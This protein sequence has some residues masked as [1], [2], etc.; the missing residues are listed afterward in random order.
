MPSEQSL[1][2]RVVADREKWQHC[3]L[4][5]GMSGTYYVHNDNLVSS[6][7]GFASLWEALDFLGRRGWQMAAIDPDVED[8]DEDRTVYW[9]KRRLVG[10]AIR[11]GHI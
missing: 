9:F 10:D 7:D 6:P 5:Q 3:S 8:S 11:D 4:S 2:F 1:Q